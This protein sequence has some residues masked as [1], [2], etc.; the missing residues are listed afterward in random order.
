[1]KSKVKEETVNEMPTFDTE[2]I[3]YAHEYFGCEAQ[4][5]IEQEKEVD[6]ETNSARIQKQAREWI[7]KYT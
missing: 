3:D 1:M 6:K 5:I 4:E 7:K 2:N